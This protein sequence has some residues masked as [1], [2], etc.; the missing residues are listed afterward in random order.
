MQQE[1][2]TMSASATAEQQLTT[3]LRLLYPHLPAGTWLVVSWKERYFQSRWFPV[4]QSK[5]LR[6]FI[7]KTARQHDVY[8]GLGLRQRQTTGRG[9]SADVGAIGTLWAEFDHSG[10]VHSATNL[11]SRDELLQFLERLP[12]RFSLIV[13]STG[14]FQCYV[15]LRELWV[16]ETAQERETAQR[17]LRRFQRSLQHLA[18]QQGFPVDT[19]SDLSRVLRPPSS[20]NH[21]SGTPQ[22]VTILQSNDIRYDPTELDEAYWMLAAEAQ[23]TTAPPPDSDTPPA[24]LDPIVAGCAWLRHCRDDAA[25]LDEP[26]WYAL[27]GLIGRCEQGEQ[28]AHTWSQPYP[29]YD[30]QETARKLA[31]ALK[32]AG[33][34]TCQ[35]IRDDLDAAA[36]CD[37]CQHWGRLT[38]PIG[39]GY[40]RHTRRNGTVPGPEPENPYACPELPETAAIDLRRAEDASPFLNDYIAFSRQWAPRAYDRLHETVGLFVLSTINARRSKIAFGP[41]GQYPS[42]YAGLVARSTLY[43]KSTAVFIALDLLEKAGLA[44][45]L[46]DDEATPQA[47][48]QGMT[49]MV[50]SNYPE[51]PREEQEALRLRLTFA[52]Q[53]GWFY[54]EFGQHLDAIMQPQGYMAP[55]R[56]IFRRLDD[57]PTRFVSKTISRGRDRIQQPYLT[58]LANLTPADIKPFVHTGSRLWTDGYLARFAFVTPPREEASSD[59]AFPDGEM[60]IPG[61][62]VTPLPRW[63]QLLR[64]PACHIDELDD[65]RYAVHVEPLPETVYVLHEQVKTGF[66]AYDA[67]IRTLLRQRKD[68]D[69]DASYARLPLKALRMAGLLASFHNDVSNRVITLQ[70]W[71]RG[72]QIAETW[73]QGLHHLVQQTQGDQQPSRDRRL[74]ES[75]I[76]QVHRQGPQTI[77]EFARYHKTRSYAVLQTCAEALVTVGV[78]QHVNGARQGKYGLISAQE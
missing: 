30:R 66:Y 3:Y 55:F 46:A 41:R 51:L 70:Y 56:G 72:Q 8:I 38:S 21:K 52:G 19:T 48:L 49:R 13:D 57:H 32:D 35:S 67:A 76:R 12:F 31:H 53:Q 74:E 10:G 45:L 69:L 23:D 16:F 73:R 1:K 28:H 42:F 37:V 26:S 24:Q 33:P 6:P 44:A 4:D 68:F 63:H 27:L 36:Y 60:Q 2:Y 5:A 75:F 17:L 22:P 71:E 50:P 34:R 59:A 58:V 47:F 29:G 65:D 9:T 15:G 7:L 64:I 39:L 78:F 11:P 54:E 61:N 20:F 40:G 43:T 62:L 18:Q 77:T 14:G 25:T